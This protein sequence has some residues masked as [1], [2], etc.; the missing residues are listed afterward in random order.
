MPSTVIIDMAYYIRPQE[1]LKL[2]NIQI[3]PLL[4]TTESSG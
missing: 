1:K 3:G 2:N 4:F